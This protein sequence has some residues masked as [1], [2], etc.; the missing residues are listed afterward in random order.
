MLVI[1]DEQMGAFREAALCRWIVQSLE[2]CYPERAR[3]QAAGLYGLVRDAVREA[4]ANGFQGDHDLRRYVH[5]VFVLGL[6][7]PGR[8]P[9]AVRVLKDA[10][11]DRPAARLAALEQ[12]CATH[13]AST[14]AAGGR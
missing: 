7:F 12:A 14:E 4:R 6:D 8:L 2:G 11:L 1:R 9:W 10:G 3:A 5:L 13:L